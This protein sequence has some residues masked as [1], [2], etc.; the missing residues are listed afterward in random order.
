MKL[1]IPIASRFMTLGCLAVCLGVC[2]TAGAYLWQEYHMF[3]LMQRTY[4]ASVAQSAQAQMRSFVHSGEAAESTPVFSAEAA[5]HLKMRLQTLDV[6]P[7]IQQLGLEVEVAGPGAGGEPGLPLA[8]SSLVSIYDATAPVRPEGG[9]STAQVQDIV[10]RVMAGSAIVVGEGDEVALAA[11]LAGA[12]SWLL[13]GAPLMDSES[14]ISGVIVARQPAMHLRH[15]LTLPRLMVPALGAA[16]GL[17]PLI[18]GGYLIARRISKRTQALKDGFDALRH[19][20]LSHRLAE[21][22]GDE[23]GDLVNQFNAAMSGLQQEDG[24]R[25]QMLGEFQAARKQAEVATAAKGDFLANM[26]HEIRTPM[27]GI[28]GTTSLLIEMG[29]D[30]EQEELVRMIRSSGESLLHL[31]NDILDFS[32]IESDKMELEDMPVEMEKLLAEVADVFSYRAAEKQIE[33]NFH[34]DPALPRMFYGDF[35]RIKQV[36]VNLAGNAIKFTEKGEILILARQVSR[37]TA[38]GETPHLHFSVR[39]T[40]IGICPDKIGSLFQAFTQA[41]SSTT[42]KYG[43]TGLGLAICRKLCRLMGGEI[44]VISEEGQGSDFFFEIPLRAAQDEAGREEELAWLDVV[45]DRRLT[46]YSPHIT[47]RQILQQTLQQ[48]ATAAIPLPVLPVDPQS[49]S[50]DLEDSVVFIFDASEHT[51]VTAASYLQAAI[52]QG[53]GILLLLPL[54]LWKQR[55][56]FVPN[57]YTRFVKLSKPAK[58]RELLRALAELV[59]MPR[60]AVRPAPSAAPGTA[61]LRPLVP[62]ST[63]PASALPP[64]TAFPAAP[65]G[66]PPSANVPTGTSVPHFWNAS[67]V[68]APASNTQPHN[69]MTAHDANNPAWMQPP[70]PAPPTP[71]SLSG[72]FAPAGPDLSALSQSRAGESRHEASVS[73]DTTRAIAAA[74]NAGGD[75]FARQHPARIL[76]VEDQP[77]NQKIATMLLQRLGYAQVDVANN[78]Q[79]A[80]DLVSAGSYDLIFMDLQ[81]PVMGGIDAARSIRNN[82]HLK[83]QPAIIAMTGHALTGV[84]EECKEVG[85]NAFLTKPVSLDDFRKTI[86][87]CLE[88]EAALRPMVL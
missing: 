32:K 50:L 7:V 57:G 16:V 11:S 58:R 87:P 68:V 75:S 28:I 49:L 83:N 45:K 5:T 10:F 80:V 51:P 76:L 81:M 69:A 65:P 41:D 1:R 12:P 38:Q 43:G 47:T 18:L 27:N 4:L 52:R 62:S 70:P 71:P 79:E 22:S 2:V 55:D 82:F 44:S 17:L 67:T 23:L 86:P 31:I 37:K 14:R 8:A 88:K 85:M 39:D 19:G 77:L 36:L 53:A 6:P 35:Q 15:L 74:A 20:N 40:G 73:Q 66:F 26:S 64:L 30:H 29:L 59:R 84:R 33:L 72:L 46:Y 9:P 3:R 63:V 34:T 61:V 24:R 48:W 25:Q 78:G 13:A 60:A 54:T 42:R 21:H 56:Q